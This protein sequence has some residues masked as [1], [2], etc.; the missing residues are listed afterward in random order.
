MKTTATT[1]T[2]LTLPPIGRKVLTQ[3]STMQT[4][5]N[6]GDADWGNNDNIRWFYREGGYY[7]MKWR[8]VI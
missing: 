4:T 7:G 5:I 8:G 3:P 1:R 6:F 2:L